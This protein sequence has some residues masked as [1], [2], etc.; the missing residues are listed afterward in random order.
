[1]ACRSCSWV[2]SKSDEWGMHPVMTYPSNINLFT[3][4]TDE[5]NSLLVLSNE[6]WEIFILVVN[7]VVDYFRIKS[8]SAKN[9]KIRVPSC[10]IKCWGRGWLQNFEFGNLV[11]SLHLLTPTHPALKASTHSLTHS[12]THSLHWRNKLITPSQ[13]DNSNDN[14][15]DNTV[16]QSRGDR[17]HVVVKRN[18][19][20]LNDN[21]LCHIHLLRERNRD[22]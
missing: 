18:N 4:D 2:S 14:D 5:R 11:G 13:T 16:K 17:Q 9:S 19:D 7:L 8:W 3:L 10:V 22:P 12:F 15:I 21:Y 6:Y 20:T 1:M